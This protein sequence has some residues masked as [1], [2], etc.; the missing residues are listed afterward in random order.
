MFSDFS[1]C[2]SVINNRPHISLDTNWTIRSTRT[3]SSLSKI[4][5]SSN[6]GVVLLPA[7]F[8][9]SNKANLRAPT[10]D[11]ADNEIRIVRRR[12]PYHQI[13]SDKTFETQVTTHLRNQPVSCIWT[14]L[15]QP[16]VLPKSSSVQDPAHRPFSRGNYVAAMLY[17]NVPELLCKYGR[18]VI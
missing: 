16:S 6:I 7:C 13:Y 18:T 10:K 12:S 3:A 8:K 9:K 2:G 15:R 11:H 14:Y 5:S 17:Y 1:L 4:S